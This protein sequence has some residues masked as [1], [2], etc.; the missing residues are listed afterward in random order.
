M[1]DP[2]DTPGTGAEPATKE[3]TMQLVDCDSIGKLS[4]QKVREGGRELFF[5]NHN[6]HYHGPLD[7]LD[8]EDVRDL[9]ALATVLLSGQRCTDEATP[10]DTSRP[11]PGG[12]GGETSVESFDRS[13]GGPRV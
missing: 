1:R 2:H 7:E 3:R 10:L 9:I 8:A 5:F 11:A 4:G 13:G 6:G 12:T